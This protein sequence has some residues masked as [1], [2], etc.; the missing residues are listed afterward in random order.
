MSTKLHLLDASP[1]VSHDLSGKDRVSIGRTPSCDVVLEDVSIE[2]V[3]CVIER[4]GLVFQL[5]AETESAVLHVNGRPTRAQYLLPD[6]ELLIGRVRVRFEHEDT[7]DP[8]RTNLVLDS[9]AQDDGGGVVIEHTADAV[10]DKLSQRIMRIDPDAEAQHS[11][12]LLLVRVAGLIGTRNDQ[13]TLLADALD[14]ARTL[15]P[16]DRAA[17]VMRN[18]EGRISPTVVRRGA[19]DAPHAKL[20]VNQ[21]AI[22]GAAKN[23]E[24]SRG[25]EEGRT[26]V[27]VPLHNQ[28][29]AMGA[30]Y[31]DMPGKTFQYAD[32][33]LDTLSVMGNLLGLAVERGRLLD[34]AEAS[35]QDAQ[36][37]LGRLIDIFNAVGDVILSLDPKG[38]VVR[39]N[40]VALRKL[41]DNWPCT[42]RELV[43]PASHTAL[44]QALQQALQ[45]ATA[46]AI[47]TF[48]VGSG[49][50]LLQ[51]RFIPQRRPDAGVEG[52]VVVARP[53]PTAG[54]A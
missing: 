53:V 40:N 17:I 54:P 19:D 43:A 37:Q 12:L 35:A 7:A 10:R 48:K 4:K 38:E 30:V 32:H 45:G 20:R 23:G 28:E 16:G 1:L 21:R 29:G 51:T 5:R 3:H 36:L 42:I 14:A 31:L 33:H 18:K 49:D 8:G 15:L 47:L 52:L 50:E 6:D 25:E 34:R 41:G 44:A 13:L 26:F 46:D 39:W 2:P 27:C 24:A 9:D 22:A 11:G